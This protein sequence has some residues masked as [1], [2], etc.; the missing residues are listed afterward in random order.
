M[1]VDQSGY[2]I[3]T[4]WMKSYFTCGC[5]IFDNKPLSRNRSTN[6]VCWLEYSALCFFSHSFF[7]YLS[8]FMP[9]LW[10]LFSIKSTWFD[11][12]RFAMRFVSVF[13]WNEVEDC[14]RKKKQFSQNKNTYAYNIYFN[15]MHQAIFGFAIVKPHREIK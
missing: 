6:L 11:S 9:F 2:S 14:R 7:Y 13:V 10:L 3:Y 12:L 8:R 4:Q 1:Y 5:C 15:L